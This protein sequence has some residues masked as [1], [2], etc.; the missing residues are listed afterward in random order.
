[1]DKQNCCTKVDQ[2]KPNR[3]FFNLSCSEVAIFWTKFADLLQCILVPIKF[4]QQLFFKDEINQNSLKREKDHQTN[5]CVA[6]QE[7]NG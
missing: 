4:G 2:I 6:Q 7:K 5:N 3:I 1:M